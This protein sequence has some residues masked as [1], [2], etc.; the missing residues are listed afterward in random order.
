M[1]NRGVVRT[2]PELVDIDVGRAAPELMTELPA[3]P[4]VE[5]VEL[6]LELPAAEEPWPLEPEPVPDPVPELDPVPDAVPVAADPVIEFEPDP[7]PDAVP[8]AADPVSEFE[9]DPVPVLPTPELPAIEDVPLPFTFVLPTPVPPLVVVFE[10]S[11]G[12][13]E[14]ELLQAAAV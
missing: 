8:V 2:D 13:A 11:P 4:E 1:L 6:V 10:Y 7:V 12:A 9:P 14:I 5:L 3:E